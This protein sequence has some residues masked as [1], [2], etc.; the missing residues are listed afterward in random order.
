MDKLIKEAP[1]RDR[2]R[3]VLV[4]AGPPGGRSSGLGTMGESKTKKGGGLS[5]SRVRGLFTEPLSCALVSENRGGPSPVF[6]APP[7]ADDRVGF[8][9]R[10]SDEFI[11]DLSDFRSSKL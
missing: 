5:P 3:R 8:S 4:L 6:E 10:M 7:C 11:R 9:G 2:N 1:T